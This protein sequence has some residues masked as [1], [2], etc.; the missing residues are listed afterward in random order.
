[1]SG[2]LGKK[3]GM[4]RLIGDDGRVIPLTVVECT[5]NVVTQ[6][7]TSEKDGYPAIVLGFDALSKPTKTQKFRFQREFRLIDNTNAL[8]KGSEIKVDQF[9]VGEEVKITGIS[10]GK[11]F[12]GV[13]KRHHFAGG[14]R[15]HGSHFHREP[16]SI[17]MRAKPGKVLKGMRMAGQMGGDQKTLTQAK[18]VY[19]DSDKHLLGIK[20][21]IPGA[22]GGLVIIRKKPAKSS[23]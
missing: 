4:T 23:T 13:I 21:A 16:G 22:A 10:K 9:E 2:I 15:S 18:I 6:I 19:V 1:M 5:P 11:G 8:E 17:G 12:A 7:K 20:G 14:P 3:V